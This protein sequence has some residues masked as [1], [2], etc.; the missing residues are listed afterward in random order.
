MRVYGT[1][2]LRDIFKVL[3]TLSAITRSD[4]VYKT[5]LCDMC[6]F[7]FLQP[8]EK[9][10]YHIITLRDGDGKGSKAQTKFAKATRHQMSQL[11]TICVLGLWLLA[12]FEIVE[13]YKAFDFTN[14]DS[15]FNVKN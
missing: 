10:P 9:D 6:D 11:C 15:W 14:N 12:H 5:D 1:A 2:A 7:T 3:F 4:S 13:E 8:K